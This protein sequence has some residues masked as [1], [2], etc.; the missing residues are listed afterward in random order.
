MPLRDP[1]H[2]DLRKRQTH[3]LL[4]PW[5]AM[6]GCLVGGMLLSPLLSWIEARRYSRVLFGPHYA[7]DG[8]WYGFLIGLAVGVV[9]FRI[10]LR[11]EDRGPG[12]KEM[13]E[14]FQRERPQD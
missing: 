11:K 2:I 12:P 5:T 7:V 3:W 1:P 4:I 10:A 13:L 8:L 14:Y 9:R 6:F